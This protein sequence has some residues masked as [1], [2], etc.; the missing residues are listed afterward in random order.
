[1][2][3]FNIISENLFN[4]KFAAKELQRNSK[5]C[6]KEE[7]L[8]KVKVKKVCCTFPNKPQKCLLRKSPHLHDILM[9]HIIS[10][11]SQGHPER[12]YGGS[13]DPCRERHQTEEPVCELSEDE[14]SGGCSS[15]KG[16]N[17]SYNEPGTL[18]AVSVN[19]AAD[20]QSVIG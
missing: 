2:F 5:K 15:S 1:M 11:F 7:K 13:K 9:S 8:E 14:R 4:L 12:K 3:I 17:C 18:N 10:V 6:D 20:P 16:P 19:N